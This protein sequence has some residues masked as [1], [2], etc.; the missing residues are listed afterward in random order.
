MAYQQLEAVCA[1]YGSKI[2]QRKDEA[3]DDSRLQAII[4]NALGVLR[5]DGVFA[6]YLFL[7]YRK[8]DSGGVIWDEVLHLW[9]NEAVGPLMKEVKNEQEARAEVI[10]LTDDLQALL[11]AR[12]VA[13]RT[14][15][16]ALYG[17]RAGG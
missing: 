15:I 12:E 3:K 10:A 2:E 13:E 17:L 1:Q 11:L 7:Q 14:L 9:Q 8:K 16:Y 6:F 5:E 4:R